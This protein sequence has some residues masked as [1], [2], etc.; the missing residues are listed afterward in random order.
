MSRQRVPVQYIWKIR[1]K[2]DGLYSDGKNHPD[3]FPTGKHFRS[4]GLVLAHLKR[5]A[6]TKKYW[7]V[8]SP[9]HGVVHPYDQTE[10]EVVKIKLVIEAVAEL[11]GYGE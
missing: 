3:F 8:I 9:N 11:K 1:R 6:K 2:T 7:E 10:C 4:E 5:V